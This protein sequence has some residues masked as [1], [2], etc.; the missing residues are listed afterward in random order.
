MSMLQRPP[1]TLDPPP[2][3]P[4]VRSSAALRLFGCQKVLPQHKL[5][6]SAVP[7]PVTAAGRP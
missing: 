1:H 6:G 5:S 4:T 2:Q 7:G 3:L